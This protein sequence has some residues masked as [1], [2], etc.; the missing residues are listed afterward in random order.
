MMQGQKTSTLDNEVVVEHRVERPRFSWRNAIRLAMVGAALLGVAAVLWLAADAL[1]PFIIS[2]VIAYLMLPAVNLL[3]RRVPR[4]AA[5]LLVYVATFGTLGVALSYVIPPTVT[6]ISE[7]VEGIPTWYTGGRDDF[8]RLLTRFRREAPPEVQERVEEQIGR[9]QAAVQENATAYSQRVA[10]FLFNSVVRIFQTL[11]FLIGFLVIPFFLFY[12]LL[13]SQRLPR[14][15]DSVLHP[16]IRADFWNIVRIVDAIMGKYI[17]GQ[18]TLGLVVGVMSFVGLLGLNAAGFNVKFT[19]LLAL[20]AGFGELIPVVGPILSA[21]PAIIVG[22]TDSGR[23][24]LAVAVLYLVIQQIENQVL[25]PR[26]VGNTLKLHAAL[27]MALLVIASQIGGLPLVILVAPLAAIARDVFTYAH[28][29]L[30]DPPV[31]PAS[32]IRRVMGEERTTD[33]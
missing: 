24:G 21:I 22:L 20:V 11:T 28:Q 13:D 27:L 4:W 16:R 8:E 7:F 6:Q 23:T 26:I 9:V 15:I 18:L 30:H 29:R 10:E 32:A 33:A 5:I 2:L 17:R 12:V 25:V 31:E 1:T 3:S 14:A 19:V